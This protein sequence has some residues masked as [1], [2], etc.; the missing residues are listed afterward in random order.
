MAPEF[1]EAA[2]SL[3]VGAVSEVIETSFGFHI[4]TVTDKTEASETT[5]Q[6]DYY[7]YSEIFFD[8]ADDPW[9]STGLDGAN[10]QYATV[11][12]NQVGAP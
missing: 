6:E 4:I 7:T 2:F 3:E 8:S 5:T 1:E 11:T 9:K 10:F 12:Y